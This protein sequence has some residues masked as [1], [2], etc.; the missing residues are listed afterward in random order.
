MNTRFVSCF[1]I[2]LMAL[3][4]VAQAQNKAAPTKAAQNK[5]AQVP[6]TADGHPD[7]QGYWTNASFT[8][9]ERPAEFAGKEFFTEA[10]ARAWIAGRRCQPRL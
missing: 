1:A 3:A 2:S 8:P 6:R 10:E 9:L 7:F 5:A 4:V